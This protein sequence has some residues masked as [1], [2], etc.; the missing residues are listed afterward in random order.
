[1]KF[2]TFVDLHDDKKALKALIKRAS[3]KDIDFVICAGDV[4]M[5][6]RGLRP[7][8][9]QFNDLG[10]K[11]YLI[12]GNHESDRIIEEVIGDYKN[13]INYNA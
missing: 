3:A 6:G 9:K 11:F 7:V 12:P 4:S 13:V 1:M 10:K 8:L 2:L 5:F